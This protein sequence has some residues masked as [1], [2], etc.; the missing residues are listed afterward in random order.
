MLVLFSYG[1]H[2]NRVASEIAAQKQ[3]LISMCHTIKQMA[4]SGNTSQAAFQMG[5]SGAQLG[6]NRGPYGMMLGMMYKGQVTLD[7]LQKQIVKAEN[8]FDF[9]INVHFS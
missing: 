1:E 2:S 6:P 9:H 3:L 8:Y 5:P 7:I 4:D